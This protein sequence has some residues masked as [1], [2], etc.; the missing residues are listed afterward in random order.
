MIDN[1]QSKKIKIKYTQSEINS[2]NYQWSARWIC[3]SLS[4]CSATQG[5]GMCTSKLV[6]LATVVKGDQKT[7]FSIATTLRC[8]GGCYSFPWIAPL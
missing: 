7:P 1:V 4:N 3:L 5:G 2:H 6:K 8:R